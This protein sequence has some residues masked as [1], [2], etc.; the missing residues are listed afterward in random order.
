MDQPQSNPDQQ[1]RLIS[2][3]EI[4]A[5]TSAPVSS[6][7]LDIESLLPS[8]NANQLLELLSNGHCPNNLNTL[9]ESTNKAA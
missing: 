8:A 9:I 2:P 7:N 4:Q 3:D 5:D 6:P 1:D